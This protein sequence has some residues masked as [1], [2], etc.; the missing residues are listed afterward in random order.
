MV[1]RLHK[2]HRVRLQT[3]HGAAVD[4]QVLVLVHLLVLYGS[5]GHS[6]GLG[7][8]VG[9]GLFQQFASRH[10]LSAG[11]DAQR[12]RG[13]VLAHRGSIDHVHTVVSGGHGYVDAGHQTRTVGLGGNREREIMWTIRIK[14]R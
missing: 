5:G 14:I 9:V 7:G 10:G 3:G 8:R 4:A 6:S 1:I 12:T 11:G 13:P 2:R